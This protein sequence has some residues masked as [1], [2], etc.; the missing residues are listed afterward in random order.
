[1]REKVL[2]VV[3]LLFL[4]SLA[5]EAAPGDCTTAGVLTG[6][7]YEEIAVSSTALGFTTA[8]A[9]PAGAVGAML[10][11]VS[12]EDDAVRY[13]D[14]GLNPTATVGQLAKVNTGFLVCGENNIR[15]L[16]MIRQTTDAD[17][18]VSYY[19]LGDN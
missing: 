9:Y 2:A 18:H 16:R 8:T 5:V 17:V 14:D 7:A 13:R 1:M 11:V 19:R 3:M 4:G 15:R 12:V 10:A 6:F